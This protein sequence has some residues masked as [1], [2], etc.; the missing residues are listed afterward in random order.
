[1]ELEGTI[2]QIGQAQTFGNFTKREVVITTDEQYPQTILIE[3]HKDKCE[4]LD[5]FAVGKGV[6]I[7]INLRG[8]EWTN[9]QGETKVFNSIVG[10]RIDSFITESHKAHMVGHKQMTQEEKDDLPF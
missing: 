6:R 7:G 8:R 3:F 9:K 5:K 10:W 1:M 4:L 2:K